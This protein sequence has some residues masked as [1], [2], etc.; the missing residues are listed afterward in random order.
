MRITAVAGNCRRG[1]RG[2]AALVSMVMLAAVAAGLAGGGRPVQAAVGPCP[3][4]FAPD[5]ISPAGQLDSVSAVSPAD[6]WVA[7]VYDVTSK[8]AAEPLVL[9]WNGR[10]W[11]TLKTPVF[12]GRVQ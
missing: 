11:T 5:T 8:D 12:A 3:N 7:G 2:W 9:H 1:L 6:V 10:T 4:A